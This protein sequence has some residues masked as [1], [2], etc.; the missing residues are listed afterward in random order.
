MFDVNFRQQNDNVYYNILQEIR[1]GSISLD[2][3]E[4]LASCGKKKL[5]P[6]DPIVPTKIFPIKKYVDTINKE[7]I[8]KLKRKI[9]L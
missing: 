8:G 3:I 1:E 9:L 2:S 6:N 4:L 7:E 5:D